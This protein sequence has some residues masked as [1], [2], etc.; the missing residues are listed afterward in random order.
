MRIAYL[1]PGPLS[2]GPL[3][4]SELVRRQ[5]YLAERAFPGTEVEVREVTTGPASI[6]SC[7]EECLALPEILG[8]IPELE[9]DG[10]DAVIIGCFDDPG[11]A[12]SRELT[13]IPVMGPAQA[14][15][16]WAAQLGD[17]FA[18]LTV[19][20]EVIPLLRRL[21]RTYGLQNLTTDIRAVDVPVLEL[22]H[23]TE[24]VL[25]T[26]TV[27]GRTAMEGGA[28]ALILGCMTMGF[29]DVAEALERRL[30]IPVINPVLAGLKAA[31]CAVSL[32][33]TQSMR[34]YPAPRKGAM[35]V[36]V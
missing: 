5:E 1:V 22:R 7:V 25:E 12:A 13:R 23:R 19:V 20:D 6:E 15:C 10:F 31:E 17:R 14:S 26:L 8:A 29:L 28:D 24:A 4:P 33:T 18:I 36:A 30:E 35:A 11:L 9:A 3:G 27:E 2:S 21:M 32:G 16:H 34:A